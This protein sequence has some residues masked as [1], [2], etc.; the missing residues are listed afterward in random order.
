MDVSQMDI[1]LRVV[2][3]VAAFPVLI[4]LGAAVLDFLCEAFKWPGVGDR[5]QI[6]TREHP[7][8]SAGMVIFLG[9]LLGHF[10]LWARN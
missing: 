2:R 8:L 6:W 7:A 3:L 5:L 10:F 1:P 4:F 9:A